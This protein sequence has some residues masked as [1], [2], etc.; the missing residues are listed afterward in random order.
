[1]PHIG[2]LA[3]FGAPDGPGDD[4]DPAADTPMFVRLVTTRAALPWVQGQ[5]AHLE[6]R[7]NAPLPLTEATF[8]LKR[9]EAW[10]PGAPGRYA[11]VY[12][13]HEDVRDGLTATAHLDGQPIAVRFLSPGLRR[14]QAR[15]LA[16]FGTGAALA[17]FLLVS[18]AIS[19]VVVRGAASADL[20]LAEQ[21]AARQ[22]T[23]TR[24]QATLQAQARAIERAG[25]ADRR[26]VRLLD[27]LAWTVRGRTPGA[28]IERFVWEGSLFAIEVRGDESPF[29]ATD[30]PVQRSTAPVR[31]GV[32]LW[33]VT[34]DDQ[35]GEGA[36]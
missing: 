4:V 1:M 12:V 24:R 9:L 11:A 5:A 19:L 21:T 36:P 23:Q 7:L 26:A 3:D 18:T 28:A 33:G 30:R 10:R 25:L 6:A 31:P 32:W 8:L 20:A 2:P 16:L 13:R 29:A 15:Q 27:D 35:P 17:A 14:R 34:S 22:L